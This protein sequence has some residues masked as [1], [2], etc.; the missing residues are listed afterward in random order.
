MCM[1]DKPKERAQHGMW[2]TRG[3]SGGERAS[4]GH[5]PG[6]NRYHGRGRRAEVGAVGLWELLPFLKSAH[7][8]MLSSE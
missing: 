4:P 3:A 7:S 2:R 1:S 6:P 8:S 5:R